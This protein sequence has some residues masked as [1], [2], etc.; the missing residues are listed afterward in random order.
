[1]TVTIS[2]CN[3]VLKFIQ[4]Y[5]TNKIIYVEKSK[6]KQMIKTMKEIQKD[7]NIKVSE[8]H[9]SIIDIL[10]RHPDT[11]YQLNEI[12]DVFLSK[13]K[14]ESENILCMLKICNIESTVMFII[15]TTWNKLCIVSS[16][17]CTY[18]MFVVGCVVG[19]NIFLIDIVYIDHDVHF[20]RYYKRWNRSNYKCSCNLQNIK[21]SCY[22]SSISNVAD[23][24]NNY[25]CLQRRQRSKKYIENNI[26]HVFG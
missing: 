4:S 7:E 10:E 2:E 3:D 20:E 8:N 13:L 15:K 24:V 18:A 14:E 16:K 21:Q 17:F 12:S 11:V 6:Q 23:V 1:M 22:H 25:V 5:T 26:L 9:I 19:G